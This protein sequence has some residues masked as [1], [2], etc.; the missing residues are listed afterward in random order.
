VFQE[1]EGVR[2][3]KAVWREH[4]VAKDT[5]YIWKSRYGGMEVADVKRHD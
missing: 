2:T 1:V 4:G 5:L 3:V